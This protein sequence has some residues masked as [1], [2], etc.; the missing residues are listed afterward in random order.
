MPPLTPEQRR[1]LAEDARRQQLSGGLRPTATLEKEHIQEQQLQLARQAP[2]VLG[3]PQPSL[4][5]VQQD[6]QNF[7]QRPL[8]DQDQLLLNAGLSPTGA[9]QQAMQPQI[10]PGLSQHFPV[11]PP[12]VRPPEFTPTIAIQ[13]EATFT[14]PIGPS[15]TPG[16][17][18]PFT[19]PLPGENQGAASSEEGPGV[20]RRIFEHF[21]AGMSGQ[22]P[23]MIRFNRAQAKL[24]QFKV[25]DE[26]RKQQ[27]AAN[28]PLLAKKIQ[29][30][31][32]GKFINA[33]FKNRQERAV[34]LGQD[35]PT[36]MNMLD[37]QQGVAL[38][39]QANPSNAMQITARDFDTIHLYQPGKDLL[40]NSGIVSAEILAEG[41]QAFATQQ[42]QLNAQRQAEVRKLLSGATSDFIQRNIPAPGMADPQAF[43]PRPVTFGPTELFRQ[44]AQARGLSPD[45]AFAKLTGGRVQDGKLVPPTT[46]PTIKRDQANFIEQLNAAGAKAASRKPG[47]E[48]KP[49]LGEEAN[50]QIQNI[51]RAAGATDEEVAAMKP[52]AAGKVYSPNEVKNISTQF[53]KAKEKAD[54]LEAQEQRQGRTLAGAQERQLRAQLHSTEMAKI[55]NENITEYAARNAG[56]KSHWQREKHL[57]QEKMQ[58][59]RFTETERRDTRQAEQSLELMREKVQMQAGVTFTLEGMR[60]NGRAAI[61]FAQEAAGLKL[62]TVRGVLGDLLKSNPGLGE[63]YLEE[64]AS[65]RHGTDVVE[66]MRGAMIDY[67][68]A[69]VRDGLDA[70]MNRLNHRSGATRD[71]RKLDLLNLLHRKDGKGGLMYK[72]GSPERERINEALAALAPQK[73]GLA[74]AVDAMT[75]ALNP[76]DASLLGKKEMEKLTIKVNTAKDGVA[77]SNKILANPTTFTGVVGAWNKLKNFTIGTALDM[78][79]IR[80]NVD[81]EAWQLLDP[82]NYADGVASGEFLTAR[83]KYMIAR[84]DD[85]GGRITEADINNVRLPDGIFS[86]NQK[87]FQEGMRAARSEFMRI[88]R[89]SNDRLVRGALI[90]TPTPSQ[91]A[92]VVQEL[93]DEFRQNPRILNAPRQQTQEWIQNRFMQ[94]DMGIDAGTTLINEIHADAKAQ[95]QER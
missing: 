30:L 33:A 12:G 24:Q 51:A 38:Y 86:G 70:E 74:D 87:T 95:Y 11:R 36:Q 55:K 1:L 9:F 71:S 89:T 61:Q 14:R 73:G 53:F 6:V 46:L 34:T 7:H 26:V 84:S 31:K 47:D 59:N 28:Y 23:E 22:T 78:D 77:I 18:H 66:A 52:F 82:G 94:E 29:S 8:S 39:N 57:H 4:A 58:N 67:N 88:A 16:V 63:K 72:D 35:K 56:L 43:G 75:R 27:A 60:Q 44:N 37:V 3:S 54:S 85:P 49:L 2:P 42:G 40:T 64:L 65:G 17:R 25:Q 76:A 50:A 68:K 79:L 45:Q 48:A 32:A 21:A 13:P 19:V 41:A 92:T 83:L 93:V 69:L 90:H 10:E 80:E 20:L 91:R 62:G 5:P 15:P 81:D